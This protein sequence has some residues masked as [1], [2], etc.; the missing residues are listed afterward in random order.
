M[1]PWMRLKLYRAPRMAEAMAQVRAELGAEAVI[2]ATRRVA[3]GVEVTAGLDAPEPILIPP[4]PMAAVAPPPGAQ[5][6]AWHNLPS[7]LAA[8]LG[9]EDLAER[10]GARLR[11]APLPEG[12]ARPLLLVGPP[13]AGKTIT[14]AK[15]ATRAVVAGLRPV[16]VTTDAARA[17][18]VEQLAAFTRMLD[19]TLAVAAAPGTA[20][21]A[22]ARREAGQPALIDSAGCD[23]FDPEQATSLRAL[24]LALKADPVLV[25]PAGLDPGEAAELA[26]G[27]AEL[28]ARHLLATRLDLSR[29]LGGVLAAAATGLALTEAGIGPGAAGGLEPITAEW[30]AARLVAPPPPPRHHE[31][32]GTA[33]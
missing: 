21:K 29:R 28:G 30:V 25:L 9:G 18:A 6:L 12:L 8:Q 13:G 17:G 23:P 10:L 3:G 22:V 7:A 4:G 31:Q 5:A 1:Q 33:A 11:F 19:L 26:V 16:I 24:A 14:C 20:V 2:L 15:L 32:Q 27:F